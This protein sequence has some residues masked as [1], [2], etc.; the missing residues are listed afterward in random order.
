MDLE[1]DS[2][3]DAFRG[4]VRD[5]LNEHR[6]T[7][8]WG[9]MEGSKEDRV[10][11][12]SQQIEHGYWART[13]PREYGGFGA[14]PDL[15]ETV[16]MDEEFN[17]AG[18]PRGMNAQGPSMLVPT[19]LNHGSEEQ[20]QRW[21]GPTMRSKRGGPPLPRGPIPMVRSR[22]WTP[23]VPARVDGRLSSPWGSDRSNEAQATRPWSAC[24][25]WLTFT[26]AI[27]VI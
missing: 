3:Y 16:I 17:K 26:K 11:W 13:I 5:F 27:A 23:C 15:L 7:R 6:P 1:F 18:V 2:R 20:R 14:E 25:A 21:I 12:L 19:L 10:A 9:L 4:Q 22:L 24:C 8:P